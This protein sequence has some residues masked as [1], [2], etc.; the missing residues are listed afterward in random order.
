MPTAMLAFPCRYT[1]SPY[2][3]AEER[4]LEALADLLLAFIT[5]DPAVLS[6]SWRGPRVHPEP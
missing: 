6:D 2:E 1:H 4:D 5:T 3:T